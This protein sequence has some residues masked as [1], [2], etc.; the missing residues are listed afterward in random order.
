MINLKE[1]HSKF[2]KL[3]SFSNG[4]TS[5]TNRKLAEEM[6]SQLDEE[7]F[8]NPNSKFLDPCAGTGTF[9]AVLH[10]ILLKYHD[11]KWIFEKMIFMVDISR[12]NCDL[13]KKIGFVNV[14]NDDFL[15]LK[16]NMIFDVV[17]GNSPFQSPNDGERNIGAPLWPMFIK[18]SFEIV[19]TNG[20]VSLV[21]PATWLNRSVRGAWGILKENN[22]KFI[23]P[24]AKKYFPNVGGHAGTFSYFVAEKTPYEGKTQLSSGLTLDIE[25]TLLPLNTRMID[26]VSINFLTEMIN[27]TVNVDVKSGPVNPSINSNHWSPM[28]TETH[29][30]ETYYSGSSTR[31]SIWCDTPIGD[32][33]VWKLVVASS[34]NIY[35][36][37][38]ITKKGVGRQGNYILGSK[39]QL[40][41]LKKLL[42]NDNSKRLTELMLNGNYNNALNYIIGE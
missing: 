5:P 34:G 32:F 24:N 20:L 13:L 18:K 29:I 7:I 12:V 2:V 4:A 36:T 40:E 10:D 42:L 11:S 38:E 25:S 1:E 15:N 41:Y 26:S 22:I 8:K 6:I 19:K 16:L 17:V 14:Y 30:Y 33:G 27:K 31:R 37:L 3:Y 21:T 35:D 28:K 9:G 23:E 39:K